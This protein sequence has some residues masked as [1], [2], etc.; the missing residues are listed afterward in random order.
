MA[1]KGRISLP[2]APFKFYWTKSDLYIAFGA[3]AI[4]LVRISLVHEECI[5]GKILREPNPSGINRS[6]RIS[7]LSHQIFLPSSAPKRGWAFAIHTPGQDSSLSPSPSTSTTTSNSVAEEPVAALMN[8][9]P[10]IDDD[11][12][13]TNLSSTILRRD[14]SPS[15]S[16][17]PWISPSAFLAN[18]ILHP[19]I[20]E[21]TWSIWQPRRSTQ[22]QK[23]NSGNGTNGT[24]AKTSIDNGAGVEGS[25]DTS[26]GGTSDGN[27]IQVT[28]KLMV[29]GREWVSLEDTTSTLDVLKGKYAAKDRAFVVPIRS[30]LEWW[31][32]S[33]VACW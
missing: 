10:S 6:T 19:R 3:T 18:K 20:A 13:A 22:S 17:G 23:P 7:L 4:K 1:D 26:D 11:I 5:N 21:G 33:F 9:N 28:G 8:L 27:G 16:L 12:F 14:I 29:D 31:R 24:S 30:G 2:T 15:S 32:K 25:R